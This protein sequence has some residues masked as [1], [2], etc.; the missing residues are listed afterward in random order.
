MEIC[1]GRHVL[2][3]NVWAKGIEVYVATVRLSGTQTA[4]GLGAAVDRVDAALPQRRELFGSFAA[5]DWLN[6]SAAGLAWSTLLGQIALT[7]Q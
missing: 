7:L 1:K 4:Q 5:A 2:A 3:P 6:A